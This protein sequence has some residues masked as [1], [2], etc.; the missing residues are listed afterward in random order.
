MPFFIEIGTCDFDTLLPL[1]DNGW[2]GIIVEPMKYYIDKLPKNNNVIYEN[3]CILPKKD[4]PENRVVDI[5]YWDF[6]FVKSG[7]KESEWMKGVSSCDL[8]NN[9]FNA[10]PQWQQYKKSTSVKATSID[11]LIDNN[12]VTQIDFM[13]IDIEGLDF[14]ILLD[15]SFK[16][17]PRLIKLES[18]FLNG[19][20]YNNE[21]IKSF[22]NKLGYIVYF[23]NMDLYAIC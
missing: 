16:I 22:F 10:N 17:K 5:Q 4:I 6:D 15:Y 7:G 2:S 13:K 8:N 1:V 20:G 3:C 21:D 23:E 14:D 9:N 12:N 18:K 19:R 11:E